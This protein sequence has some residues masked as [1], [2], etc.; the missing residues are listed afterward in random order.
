MSIT[1]TIVCGQSLGQRGLGKRSPIF[2][3]LWGIN[4]N[5]NLKTSDISRRM[6]QD[7]S[8]V[9]LDLI[10]IAAYVYVADQ[11]IPRGGP[12]DIGMGRNWRRSFEFTIPVRKHTLWEASAVKD[13]LISTLGFLSEDDYSFTFIKAL[14]PPTSEPYFDF[15]NGQT[16]GFQ[17]D[18][19]AL[20]SGGLDSFAGAARGCLMENKNIALVSHRSVS[21]LDKRQRELCRALAERC[22]KNRPMQISVWCNKRKLRGSETTQRTR[23]FLFAALAAAVASMFGLDTIR[24]YE[25]GITTFNLWDVDHLVAARASRTTHPRVLKGFAKLFS[26][27]LEKD[28]TIENPFLYK[29]KADIFNVIGDGGCADLLKHTSSCAH[30][31][32]QSKAYSHCGKCSQCIDRRFGALASNYSRHDPQEMYQVDLVTGGRETSEE[33]GLLEGYVHTANNRFGINNEQFYKQY[34]REMA[35]IWPYLDGNSGTAANKIL[36]LHARHS[37][38]IIEVIKQSF[39]DNA[40]ELI[41]GKFPANSLLNLIQPERFKQ[42]DLRS[43]LKKGSYNVWHQSGDMWE[44]TYEGLTRY[45]KDMDGV[46]YI[47][48]LLQAPNQQIHVSQLYFQKH[49]PPPETLIQSGKSNCAEGYENCDVMSSDNPMLDDRAIREYKDRRNSIQ[50]DLNEAEN[51]RDTGRIQMLQA[52]KQFIEEELTKSLGC[53]AK[54]R[55]FN[56]QHDK[57]RVSVK[58]AISRV[59]CKIE[60][61]NFSLADHLKSHLTTGFYCHYHNP[62][63][64]LTSWQF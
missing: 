3:N 9:M 58:N 11:Q 17:A 29:T 44:I 33:R 43:D 22:A 30:T 32:Q 54:S 52:E 13:A 37:G 38:Q 48:E 4:P 46:T 62:S 19:V 5:I 14:D 53:G 49:P 45:I 8:E 31:H 35:E 41:S 24:F 36:E 50:K 63:T 23:S 1:R 40:S 7:L 51:L 61:E 16:S 26:L 20:F 10:E 60:K 2:L 34:A 12:A 27:L 18:E 21:K 57:F 56:S 28:F 15:N 39:A 59:I 42:D 6:A 47:R 64:N 25:N 55:Q